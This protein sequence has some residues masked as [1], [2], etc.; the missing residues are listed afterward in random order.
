MKSPFASPTPYR[1][2]P[3]RFCPCTF[4]CL[5]S[6][7]SSGLIGPMAGGSF[8]DC[9]LYARG[10]AHG[11]PQTLTTSNSPL[12]TILNAFG[13]KRLDHGSHR[14]AAAA[15]WRGLC[16]ICSFHPTSPSSNHPIPRLYFQDNYSYLLRSLSAIITPTRYIMSETLNVIDYIANAS[17]LYCA[18]SGLRVSSQ[19]CLHIFRHCLTTCR[20]YQMSPRPLKASRT[21]HTPLPSRIHIN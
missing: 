9:R 4:N 6:L 3:V 11:K 7:L 8:A 10:E 20:I 17:R 21:L 1:P 13:N 14:G 18:I 5:Q 2:S 12:F 16:R 15:R 19:T